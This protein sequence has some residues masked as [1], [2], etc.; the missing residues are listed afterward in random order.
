MR[1]RPLCAACIGLLIAIWLCRALGI[2]IFGEPALTQEEKS[3]LDGGGQVIV[4]GLVT[5]RRISSETVR[6][7]LRHVQVT[8]SDRQIPFSGLFVSTEYHADN[9]AAEPGDLLRARGELRAVEQAGNPGQFDAAAYYACQKIWYRLWAEQAPEICSRRSIR[10]VLFRIREKLTGAYS[11]CMREAPAGIL[12]AMLMGDKA[13][14][15]EESR[16]NFQTGGCLHLLVISGLHVTLL[17]MGLLQILLRLRMPQTPACLL[18][19]VCMILY[20]ALT[21]FPVAAVRAC[22]MFLVLVAAR[23]TRWSY[24]SACSLSLAAIL[25]LLTNPGYLFHAGFQLSFAAAGAAS[26][27]SP[28]LSRFLKEFFGH[29]QK[30]EKDDRA[31][32]ESRKRKWLQNMLQMIKENTILWGAVQLCTLPLTAYYFFEIPVWSLPLNL[33]LVPCVQYVLGAGVIG[34]LALM[35]LPQAGKLLLFPADLGLDLYDRILSLARIIPGSSVVCG[36]PAIWQMLVYYSV[37]IYV[38]RILN[39]R[40]PKLKKCSSQTGEK[41]AGGLRT[42]YRCTAILAAACMVLFLRNPPAFRLVMANV[43]QGDCILIQSG[44]RVFLSDGGSTDVQNVGKYRILPYLESQAVGY[45]DAAYISHNDTDHMNGIEEILILIAEKQTALRIGCICMPEWMLQ[46]EDGIRI[47][48]EAH[49]AGA[50]VRSLQRGNKMISGDLCIEVLHPFRMYDEAAGGDKDQILERTEVQ[51]INGIP[52]G[53][54]QAGN[55]G[56][57]V[58]QISYHGFTALLTGDLEKEGENELLPYLSDIDCLKV[59]H[60][61]SRWSTSKEF[62]EVTRPEI[63]LVSAPAK[64]MYGHPHQETLDRLEGAGAAIFATKDAGAVE[65]RV[66]RSGSAQVFTYL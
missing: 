42:V 60:H 20:T 5:E 36:R 6:Y 27:V 65:I 8:L 39:R 22:I 61:G 55:A 17:G 40:I 25:M 45:V 30:K 13:F 9:E 15:T 64:S 29:S 48:A 54:A 23:V 16:R 59:G 19:A 18:S 43:N 7:T 57:V 44:K 24:D 4:T 3:W 1:K 38:L 41:P 11:G 37:L 12:S 52:T 47:A 34:S 50:G 26:L 35:F 32:K 63:A 33:L 21:G 49:A 66:N 56:S 10:K 2:P 46:T 14:L 62:L 53:G 51:I 28:L 31:A 58:L